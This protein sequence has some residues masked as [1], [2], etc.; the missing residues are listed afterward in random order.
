VLLDYN[1]KWLRL[2]ASKINGYEKEAYTHFEVGLSILSKDADVG[3]ATVAVSK[4]LGLSFIPIT[5]ERFDMILGKSTFFEKGIQAFIEVLNSEGFRNRVPRLGNYD[6][7]SS[8]KILFTN[9]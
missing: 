7:R 9:N 1:L 2:P 5:Q 6:F 4:L 3:I 8:G